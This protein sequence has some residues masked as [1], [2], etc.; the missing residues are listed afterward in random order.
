MGWKKVFFFFYL[1]KSIA[2]SSMRFVHVFAFMAVLSPQTAHRFFSCWRWLKKI[3]TREED[4][5]AR[6]SDLG[7]H[8]GNMMT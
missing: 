8:R 2:P 5:Q 4:I 7:L 3:G 6:S 1:V